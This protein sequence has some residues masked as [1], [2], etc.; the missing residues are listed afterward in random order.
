[1]KKKNKILEDVLKSW[2]ELRKDIDAKTS[3]SNNNIHLIQ[4]NKTTV[5]DLKERKIIGFENEVSEDLRD[6]LRRRGIKIFTENPF[7]SI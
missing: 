6:Y 3:L 7:K 5:F 4:Q 2:H 1:M